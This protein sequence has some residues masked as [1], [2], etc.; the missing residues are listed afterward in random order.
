MSRSDNKNIK[1]W[2]LIL[3]VVAAS[4]L[5]AS[6]LSS[7][8]GRR[9]TT[10]LSSNSEVFFDASLDPEPGSKFALPHADD[11]GHP[12]AG[13]LLIVFLGDCGACSSK[14]FDYRLLADKQL[15]VLI[16]AKDKR[17][18]EAPP[19]VL[20]LTDLRGALHSEANCENFV[21][22]A[23]IL[24]TGHRLVALQD[25]RQTTDSFVRSVD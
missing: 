8:W 25:I 18:K 20:W 4:G 16:I 14:R 19:Y 12:L 22:R 1:A 9:M 21:P 3:P 13:S 6:L 15:P 11:D 5:A 7:D 2:Q 17:R 23:G 24:D 10:S